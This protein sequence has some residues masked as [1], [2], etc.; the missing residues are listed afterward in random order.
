MKE[1]KDDTKKRKNIP[2][3]W[4]RRINIAKMTILLKAFYRFSESPIKLSMAFFREVE[5]KNLKNLWGHKRSWI[6]QS[7]LEK[8]KKW[9]WQNP[10][11]WLQTT[12]RSCVIKTL[13]SWNKNRNMYTNG[14]PEI[15]PRNKTTHLWSINLQQRWQDYIVEGRSS[16]QKMVLRKLDRCKKKKKKKKKERKEERY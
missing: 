3:S 4:I 6:S 5:Q 9:S 2:C 1:I 8:K 7:N 12:L 16:F 14:T 11:I 10:T 13:W 15:K